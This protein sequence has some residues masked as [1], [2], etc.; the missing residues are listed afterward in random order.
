MVGKS[1][2]KKGIACLLL[3]ATAVSAVPLTGQMT[4]LT[5]VS[6]EAKAKKAK[7]RN[8]IFK[9]ITYKIPKRYKY[10]KKGSISEKVNGK[11]YECIDYQVNAVTADKETGEKSMN[12]C[13]H[14]ISIGTEDSM[15]SKKEM[16]NMGMKVSDIKIAGYKA[17]KGVIDAVLDNGLDKTHVVVAVFKKGKDIIV[18]RSK[19]ADEIDSI[20]KSARKVRKK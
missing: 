17:R 20:L 5:A 6:A 16:K 2:L 3:A 9:G 19:E 15:P 10:N 13:P 4:Q 11:T 7:T 18:I 12:L 8:V 1:R 14:E